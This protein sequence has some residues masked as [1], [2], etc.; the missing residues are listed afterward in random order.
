MS[1]LMN[2][3][4]EGIKDKALAEARQYTVDALQK[5]IAKLEAVLDEVEDF[6]EGQVDVVDGSY[7]EPAPNRAMSLMTEIQEARGKHAY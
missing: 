4:L 5:K 6:L 7:G 2:T 3:L 1:E